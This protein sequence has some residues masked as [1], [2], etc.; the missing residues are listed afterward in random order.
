M[1]KQSFCLIDKKLDLNGWQI[2]ESTYSCLSDYEK[3]F[4]ELEFTGINSQ[5]YYRNRLQELGFSGHS[6]VLDVGCGMGQWSVAMSDL[7]SHV[8]GIDINIG[9]LLVARDISASMSTANIDFSYSSAENTPFEENSFDAIFC[10]GVFMFT[11][12]PKTLAEFNRLLKPNGKLYLNVNSVGWYL[13]LL[14]D[15]GLKEKSFS[16]IKTV[17]LMVA[18]TWLG[19]Q[20]NV[21]VSPK[22]L[23][24]LL[25]ANGFKL[26]TFGPEGTI[27]ADGRKTL[28][29]S[30]YPTTFYGCSAVSEVLAHKIGIS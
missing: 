7:N 24:K 28:N 23:N 5:Q 27:R 10:Y 25:I 1:K 8:S 30:K 29:K 9:R 12:M 4:L 18:R 17:L 11:D 22:R 19:K 14:F 16:M 6:K 21:I 15:N 20:K 26:S 13:H 3:H 2:Y